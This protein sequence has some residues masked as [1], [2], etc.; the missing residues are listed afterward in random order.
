M[1]RLVFMLLALAAA[2]EA[3]RAHEP[4]LLLTD[5]ADGT[6]TAEAGFSDNT[7][8][9]GLKLLLRD[10]ATGEIT[11]EHALPANGK[12]TLKRPPAPYRVVFEGGPG[13]RVSK[14]GPWPEETTTEPAGSPRRE[15]RD[16]AP[17]PAAEVPAL[18]SQAT[19][20]ETSAGTSETLRV[21]LVVGIFFLFG[22]VAFALGHA[23]G[24][25]SR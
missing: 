21:A 2:P 13:H 12:L 15:T 11:A 9:A 5:N 24:R 3:L 10:R 17:P 1:L 7:S 25:R 22:T 6:F 14:P 4:F 8:P 18:P 16:A 20:S 23:A 19:P